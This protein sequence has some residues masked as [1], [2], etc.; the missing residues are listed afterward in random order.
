MLTPTH[1]TSP[2]AGV[3]A[4][5]HLRRRSRWRRQLA[6]VAAV[7]LSVVAC[8]PS[9]DGTTS[10]ILDAVGDSTAT[11][12]TGNQASTASEPDGLVLVGEVVDATADQR[13]DMMGYPCDW[14]D[15]PDGAM[16]DSYA[17]LERFAAEMDPSAPQ[18]SVE[19]VAQGLLD[20]GQA[21]E[22]L[23]DLDGFTGIAFRLPSSPLVF[24][25]TPLAG[26]IPDA[27]AERVGAPSAPTE[28]DTTASTEPV[29]PASSEPQGFGRMLPERYHPV[30]G[31]LKPRTALIIEPYASVDE[32][33][34]DYTWEGFSRL[35][36]LEFPVK[37]NDCRQDDDGVTEGAAVRAIFSAKPD[38]YTNVT[39]LRD[40]QATPSAISA[41][42]G[43]ADAVHLA[44]HGS[45][46]CRNAQPTEELSA[47]LQPGDY[48]P[49]VCYTMIALGPLSASDR[50]ALNAGTLTALP[51]TSF[52]D[53]RW[54][55]TGDFIASGAAN[56]AIVYA[57]NCTSADGRLASAGLAGFVGWH[58]YARQSGAVDAAV[59]FWTMMVIDGTEFDVA[60]ATLQDEGLHRSAPSNSDEHLGIVPTATLLA[61]GTNPRARDV[62]TARIDGADLGGQTLR[63]RGVPG[64]G[65]PETF[66]ADE[67]SVTFELEG[68][69]RGTESSV[70][71]EVQLDGVELQSDVQL[72][73][74]GSIVASGADWDTWRVTVR[75][76]AI[77]IPATVAAD[78]APGATKQLEVRAYER[79]SRYTADAGEVL[80]GTKLASI[81]PLP[82]FEELAAGMPAEGSVEGNE[83]RIEFDT[84]GGPVTG[85]MR[86][87]MNHNALGELGYWTLDLTGNYDPA[88]GVIGGDLVGTAQATVPFISAG[89]FGE[90]TWTGNVDLDA[91]TLTAT[92]G[93][94]GSTQPYDGM[95]VGAS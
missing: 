79:S 9:D 68:V 82:I 3:A 65:A 51:G 29:A 72:A 43:S 15:A 46:N 81:G 95:V 78:Y 80:L 47:S 92:L 59:R 11:P 54:W 88:T 21:A 25:D 23:P 48:D 22:V 62:V 63:V 94:G 26:P 71:I 49:S 6:T 45:S 10:E 19:R 57:S 38:H 64:D 86:V 87:S 83:L 30:G 67:Q 39:Y 77:Q 85:A 76:D 5:S 61:G 42:I 31:P 41:A 13:C 12:S 17:L 60:Y 18:A 24:L 55:A 2:D 56:D 33:C 32:R 40:D 27:P 36:D 34:T 90:G 14:A 58:K 89:D 35:L 74:D 4:T 73:R 53:S 69:K 20:D 52:S 93:V 7:S 75:P 84:A 16:A 50:R 91:A 28:P 70:E 1:R 8:S 37:D 44:T 66:P